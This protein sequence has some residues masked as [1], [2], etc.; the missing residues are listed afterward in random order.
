MIF[1]VSK[2][3]RPVRALVF[4]QKD[5]ICRPCFQRAQ[6]YAESNPSPRDILDQPDENTSGQ[7]GQ[8][9][10]DV[11]MREVVIGDNPVPEPPNLLVNENMRDQ[12]VLTTTDKMVRNYVRKTDR[13]ATYTREQLLEAVE[14]VKNGELKAYRAAIAYKIP[15][16]TIVAR[17][18]E[19]CSECGANQ[20][21]NPELRM[22]RFPTL[23]KNK[24]NVYQL[25]S[26]AMF[27]Y[28]DKDWF[29]LQALADLQK[30]CKTQSHT[31]MSVTEEPTAEIKTES[32][33]SESF[34][35]RSQTV[36]EELTADTK[37]E[38]VPSVSSL[39]SDI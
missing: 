14:K 24:D 5:R 26:W 34:A 19:R 1:C 22:H 3:R 31:V 27:C 2:R 16:P 9:I 35:A 15:Q 25:M 17:V 10:R 28:P 23:E 6:R 32:V 38:S 18:Y 36:T 37:T 12:E 20:V 4:D 30:S 8:E 7:P 13:A 21:S 11:S 33:T 29:N 39:I